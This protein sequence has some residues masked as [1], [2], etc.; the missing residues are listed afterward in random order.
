MI[1]LVCTQ[2]EKQYLAY[3]SSVRNT[4][5]VF[6]SSVCYGKWQRSKTFSEQ[7]KAR[8][9]RTCSVGDCGKIH[10]GRGFCRRHYMES[11]RRKPKRINKNHFDHACSFC[12]LGFTDRRESSKFCSAR[13]FGAS[14]KKS[15]IVKKGYKKVLVP[16]HHRADKK[17]YVFDHVLVL[18]AAI[19]RPLRI[20]EVTHHIDGNKLNNAPSNLA[21]CKSQTEHMKTYH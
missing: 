5:R 14:I 9:V 2:C 10:F 19:G 15:F 3:L 12:G 8:P 18:E 20:G 13:C 4:K 16:G 1:N 7:G 11:T 6:C 21:L 17:G